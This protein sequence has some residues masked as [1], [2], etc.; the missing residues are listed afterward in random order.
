MNTEKFQNTIDNLEEK[1]NQTKKSKYKRALLGIYK[2]IS[3]NLEDVKGKD[4]RTNGIYN[5]KIK[6]MTDPQKIN[7]IEYIG[8]KVYDVGAQGEANKIQK[9]LFR[10]ET[11]KNNMEQFLTKTQTNYMKLEK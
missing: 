10:N 8:Q 7:F 2:Q 6:Q 1:L 9:H 3:P 4:K 11:Y 5:T